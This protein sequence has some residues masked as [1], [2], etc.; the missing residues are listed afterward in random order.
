MTLVFG[1][2]GLL[3]GTALGWALRHRREARQRDGTRAQLL[4][5]EVQRLQGRTAELDALLDVAGQESSRLHAEL[6]AS[7]GRGEA[8]TAEAAG[9]LHERDTLEAALAEER[10]ARA[11]E[12]AAHDAAAQAEAERAAVR[13]AEL[14][15]AQARA[16]D[17]EA[18]VVAQ[19]A[20]L[21]ARDATL[22]E[23]Q[24]KVASLESAAGGPAPEPD[25]LR[26]IEGVGRVLEAMLHE[27]GITTYHQ[28]AELCADN[29]PDG[30]L[31]EFLGRIKR[32]EWSAQ[33]RQLH[34]LK[35][36]DA[37]ED[38]APSSDAQDSDKVR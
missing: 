28:V 17:A 29:A 36:S 2:L 6:A 12:K 5:L 22:T 14:E 38:N 25:D 23:L 4:D 24:H 30:R 9:L 27:A 33:A 1:V 26:M 16:R 8:L 15:L 11:Q 3:V 31:E 7:Q 19:R 13:A 18:D 35:Y 21:D 10:S 32:E 20:R 37:A 34:R